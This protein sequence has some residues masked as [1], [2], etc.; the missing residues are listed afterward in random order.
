MIHKCPNCFHR[1]KEEDALFRCVSIPQ[2]C[3]HQDDII[4]KE[5]HKDHTGLQGRI[6]RSSPSTPLTKIKN[7]FRPILEKFCE[8]CATPTTQRLCPR[9]HHDL[10]PL[11]FQGQFIAIGFICQRIQELEAFVSYLKKALEKGLA[12]DLGYVLRPQKSLTK[13]DLYLEKGTGKGNKLPLLHLK[14]YPLNPEKLKNTHV[15]DGLF[16]FCD[17]V[18]AVE[19]RSY[20]PDAVNTLLLSQETDQSSAQTK[21]TTPVA[22]VY[23]CIESLVSL[24]PEAH[25]LFHP[26]HHAGGYNQKDGVRISSDML[27][28]T[29]YWFGP[30]ILEILKKHFG[31]Y[32]LFCQ[33]FSYPEAQP[34]MPNSGW[35]VEDPVLWLLSLLKYI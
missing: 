27:A 3:P 19:G 13:F 18:N 21:I 5:F 35:R 15:F 10:D 14:F 31:R 6:L 12:H 23:S 30:N 22:L 9:C 11:F 8:E 32:R 2:I 17:K 34:F 7:Y 29:G 26:P 4:Y 24:L 28:Y 16:L 33:S 20:V 25:P 1:F